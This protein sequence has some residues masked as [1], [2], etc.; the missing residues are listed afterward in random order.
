MKR[1]LLAAA[2]LATL[3]PGLAHAQDW[4]NDPHHQGEARPQQQ[5]QA[6]P[7]AAPQRGPVPERQAVPQRGVPERGVP[8]RGVPERGAPGR[9]FVG[10]PPLRE[11]EFSHGGRSFERVHG[12]VY[13]YPR[14]YAYRRWEIGVFLPPVFL[15][16]GYYYTD[17]APL[18]LAP[19]PPGYA[20]LRYGPDLLL[21]NVY[22]GQVIDAVYGVFW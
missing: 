18:G 1:A 2:C 21:V 20:W 17:W 9:P 5:Q 11:G 15:T 14:G 6:H 10:G 16:P 22:N 12:P 19:P 3:L 13:V 8:E 4:Q 7:Q